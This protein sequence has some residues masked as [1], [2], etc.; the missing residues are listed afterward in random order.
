[1]NGEEN[2]KPGKQVFGTLSFGEFT[3][4]DY[5]TS[6]PMLREAVL[7]L[8]TISPEKL[9]PMSYEKV[10]SCVYRCVCK[11]FAKQ[12]HTDLIDLVGTHLQTA[13]L[14]LQNGANRNIV[15]QF[16]EILR[17]YNYALTGIVP[18]FAYL[19]KYYVQLKLNSNLES[20]LKYLFIQHV[21]ERHIHAI[22]TALTDAN[23]HPFSV[24][25]AMA[26]EVMQTLYQLKPEYAHLHPY[27]F[28]KY[29]PGVLEPSRADNLDSYIEETRRQQ[30][31]LMTHPD[32]C[33]GDQSRKR[34][35]EDGQ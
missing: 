32:F 26:A 25:P 18:I 7:T 23:L 22:I 11:Q 34:P 9:V 20:E 27:L 2:E 30:Q 16:G 1:M 12:L 28:A 15:V 14:Q 5:D 10:Y 8:L 21:C 19:N 6:W 31:Q 13:S 35:F 29:V 33:Q 4:E 17:Q 3:K 24:P